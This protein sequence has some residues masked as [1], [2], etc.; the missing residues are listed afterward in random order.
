MTSYQPALKTLIFVGGITLA[1][2]GTACHDQDLSGEQ[3]LHESPGSS[4]IIGFESTSTPALSPVTRVEMALPTPTPKPTVLDASE[5]ADGAPSAAETPVFL[6]PSTPT[7]KE[8]F[9]DQRLRDSCGPYPIEWKYL[10]ELERRIPD[11]FGYTLHW[12]PD[13]KSI[14]FDDRG[15]IMQVDSEGTRLQPLVDANPWVEGHRL[16]DDSAFGFYADLSMDGETLVY[17]TCEFEMD[18]DDGPPVNPP[19]FS[20]YNYEIAARTLGSDRVIRLTSDADPNIHPALSPDGTKVA[21]I[22]M[23]DWLGQPDAVV[24]MNI[25]GTDRSPFYYRDYAPPIMATSPLLLP[26]IWSPDGSSI[27]YRHGGGVVM[28]DVDKRT[29]SLL[30]G[31]RAWPSWSPDGAR[32]ASTK[33]IGSKPYLVTVDPRG[34][35]LERVLDLETVVEYVPADISVTPAEHLLRLVEFVGWSPSGEHILF[36]CSIGVCVV[37]LEGELVGSTPAEFQSPEGRKWWADWSPDGS[38]LVARRASY[39]QHAGTVFMYTMNPDGSNSQVLLRGGLGLLPENPAYSDFA[40]EQAACHE[41]LVESPLENAGLV[42]DCKLLVRARHEVTPS[43]I[44]NWHPSVAMPLWAGVT[45]GGEPRRV[46]EISLRHERL[47]N[48]EPVTL[49]SFIPMDLVF[50]Q[51]W[52]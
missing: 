36:P 1:M 7:Q 41:G 23:P 11:L 14:I 34:S 30:G 42:A 27:A 13:G 12:T 31:L 17:A 8:R 28:L 21:F 24:V 51:T 45:I 43:G 18:L 26:L 49:T 9:E 25:D 47:W 15:W 19:R 32:L 10:N 20:S 33:L 22:S 5:I 35:N 52:F 46:T 40:D 29:A 6:P 38:R 48:D 50:S 37:N 44:L 16:A 39:P 3:Y 2:V 4:S